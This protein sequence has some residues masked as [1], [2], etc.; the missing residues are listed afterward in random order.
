M[1]G[2]VQTGQTQYICN[3]ASGGG[4]PCVVGKWFDGD[5]C[6]PDDAE[7]CRG[8]DCTTAIAHWGDGICTEL[9]QCQVTACTG[10]THLYDD[11]SSTICAANTSEHCGS[12]TTNC[13]EGS[14][15][16]NGACSGGIIQDCGDGLT[17]L[18]TDID[19]CGACGNACAYGLD[20]ISG[21]CLG[22]TNC[23]GVNHDTT[24][25]LDHCGRCDHRCSDGTTCKVGECV[26]APGPAYCGAQTVQ[27]NTLRHCE[28][29]AACADGLLC[30]NNQ[31]IKGQGQ[32]ICNNVIVDSRSDS[33]NCGSC[34]NVCGSGFEC[35]NSAC[36]RISNLSASTTITCNAKT[37]KPYS[38]RDNCAGCGITCSGLYACHAGSCS[39]PD[40]G[41]TITF[42]AYE[43]DNNT[44]NGKERITWR[45]LD[46]KS[47]EQL[48]VI[49]EKVL[50]AK[51][52]NTTN[53]SITWEKS[54]IRSWLNGYAASYNTVGTSF[55]GNNFIDT[56][57]TAEEKSK[58]VFSNVPA[59][60]NPNFSTSPGNATTDK[61]FLLSVVEANNYFA[62]N[63]KRQADATRYAVKQGVLVKGS[64]SGTTS[65][66][67]TCTNVHCY[68]IWLLRSPGGSA[69]YAATVGSVG[70]VGHN[71]VDSVHNG[72]RPA[73]WVQY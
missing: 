18:L 23:G 36:K 45:V 24:T 32:M 50:D 3:G 29:C 11:G 9:G 37:V 25:D 33:A 61:I 53:I 4:N 73:L 39:I 71:Y 13:G 20:C 15:C 34:G 6:R 66:D 52:Y 59:H 44:A 64:E 7:H 54:T 63:A 68:A 65:S 67:G 46:R 70:D 57:F 12:H 62:T 10:D 42:G 21:K 2:V 56:A 40:V 22:S 58:I 19:N 48:L 26:V 41:E 8:V 38:D 30:E 16:V 51:P 17:D 1:D 27:L 28:S 69:K 14:E 35:V 47:N 5:A 60:A 72:V 49:S 43:Q 55:T 31:C